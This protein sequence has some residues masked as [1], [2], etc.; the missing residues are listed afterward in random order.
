MAAKALEIRF[1][2]SKDQTADVFTKPLAEAPFTA[3]RNNLNLVA[4][5]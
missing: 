3:I 4:T 2:S 5:G 1:I